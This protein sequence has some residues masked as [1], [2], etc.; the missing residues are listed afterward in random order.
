MVTVWKVAKNR[1]WREITLFL[2]SYHICVHCLAHSTNLCLQTLA[3]KIL[4]IWEALDL[5]V[6]FSQFIRYFPKWSTLFQS[7][8]DQLAPGA[9]S[10]KPLCPTRWT[11]HTRAIEVVISNYEVLITALIETHDTGRDEY[12]LKAGGYLSTMEKFSAFFWLKLS[13]LI[14]SATAVTLQGRNTTMQEAVE[15]ANLAIGFFK[16]NGICDRIWQNPPYG[17]FCENRV[18]CIFDKLYHR[19]NYQVWDRSHASLRS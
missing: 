1:I 5:V 19:A 11:V 8:Q 16:V 6:E 15:S 14:F 2:R 9:P 7:L 13:H 4:A 17:I 10:L 12:A 18:W 3:R